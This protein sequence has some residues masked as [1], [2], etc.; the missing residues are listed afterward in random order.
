MKIQPLLI[1]ALSGIIFLAQNALAIEMPKGWTMVPS[2]GEN[3][4]NYEPVDASGDD[5]MVMV[6]P[7]F[8]ANGMNAAAT[9]KD[10]AE[11]ADSFSL[12]N[13]DAIIEQDNRAIMRVRPE[14]DKGRGQMVFTAWPVGKEQMR[15][16]GFYIKDDEALHKR[17]QKTAEEII[18]T[19][20]AE[21]MAKQK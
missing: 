8:P 18:E 14:W 15:M 7:L 13:S 11:S 5:V 10:F 4:A 1:A 12:K 3:S 21:D 17:Y 6:L 16:V 20:Y 19:Q 9:L 2:D